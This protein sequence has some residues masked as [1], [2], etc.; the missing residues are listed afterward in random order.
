[1]TKQFRN[2][3]YSGMAV[4]NSF[5][6]YRGAVQDTDDHIDIL[7]QT[8]VTNK[9]SL[10]YYCIDLRII[11]TV[12]KLDFHKMWSFS[13]RLNEKNILDE[14]WLKFWRAIISLSAKCHW[15]LF[16]VIDGP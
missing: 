3:E 1:M 12:G 8:T 7:Q 11:Q 13:A 4:L 6:I 2:Q 5:E 16:G 10:Q 9:L 15:S 14:M